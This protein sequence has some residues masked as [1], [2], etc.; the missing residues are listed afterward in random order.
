[1]K[2]MGFLCADLATPRK[3]Q[4]RSK[5]YKMVEVNGAY[6]QKHVRKYVVEKF[7][8]N[9]QRSSV[10][11]ARRLASLTNERGRLIT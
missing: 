11:H 2:L 10:C 4:G 9:A 7:A 8:C 1:M 5:W 3:G 6:K